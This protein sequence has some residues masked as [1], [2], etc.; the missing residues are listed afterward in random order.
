MHRNLARASDV[1]LRF[2]IHIDTQH[3][4][5]KLPAFV[6]PLRLLPFECHLPLIVLGDVNPFALLRYP[7]TEQL[8]VLQPQHAIEVVHQLSFA[9]FAAKRHLP[10]AVLKA[11]A[12]LQ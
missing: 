3:I 9:G 6:L 10:L 5:F 7:G 2:G 1:K 8:V 4:A 11:R 12:F